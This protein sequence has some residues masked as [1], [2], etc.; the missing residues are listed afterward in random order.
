MRRSGYVGNGKKRRVTCAVCGRH[1]NV[2]LKKG[3]RIAKS[4]WNFF[5]RFALNAH[6]NRDLYRFIQQEQGDEAVE[7]REVENAM[8]GSKLLTE[9]W[10]CENCFRDMEKLRK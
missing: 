4:G 10:E 5:G 1:G 9:Y 3:G 2:E 7:T 8:R 6:A